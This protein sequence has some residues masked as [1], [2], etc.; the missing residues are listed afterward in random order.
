[1]FI[2]ADPKFRPVEKEQ[3]KKKEQRTLSQGS[4]N[5]VTRDTTS[6]CVCV[7]VCVC[8]CEICNDHVVGFYLF[9]I[10]ILRII[11]YAQ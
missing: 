1:M 9:L 10:L 5:S 2:R 11:I 3:K 8:L 6:V 7:C 4:H